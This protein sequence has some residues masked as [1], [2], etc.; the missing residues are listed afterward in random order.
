[1]KIAISMMML[2]CVACSAGCQKS[3]QGGKMTTSETGFKLD[4]PYFDT[5]IK[6]G[7]FQTIQVIVQRGIHFHQDVV[8][9][10]TG[11]KGIFVKPNRVIITDD[12]KQSAQFLVETSKDTAVGEYSLVV[13]GTPET[14]VPVSIG[15]GLQ[16]DTHPLTRADSK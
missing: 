8:V 2:L 11:S 5:H 4:I 14:G 1:M 10:V 7:E 16:V 12:G 6:Q 3:T 15:F 9:N 13:H